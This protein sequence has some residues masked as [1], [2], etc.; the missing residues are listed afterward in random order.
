MADVALTR[1]VNG[2][3]FPGRGTSAYRRALDWLLERDRSEQD[4]HP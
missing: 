3:R 2:D 4:V 1:P